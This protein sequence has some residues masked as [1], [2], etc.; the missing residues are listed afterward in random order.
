MNMKQL[1]ASIAAIL[2]AAASPLAAQQ[3]A[4]PQDVTVTNSIRPVDPLPCQLDAEKLAKAASNLS[5]SDVTKLTGCQARKLSTFEMLGQTT[6]VFEFRD[7]VNRLQIT[8]R[9]NKVVSQT[10]RKL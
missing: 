8:L 2:F 6:E 5:V 4:P 10:F 9:N 7:G 3:A 1:L